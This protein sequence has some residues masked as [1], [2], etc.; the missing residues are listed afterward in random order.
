MRGTKIQLSS[1][2]LLHVEW[3]QPGD[4]QLYDAAIFED[5]RSL[6]MVTIQSFP[7]IFVTPTLHMKC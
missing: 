1:K 2:Y 7:V 6:T 4:V 3:Y 5:R